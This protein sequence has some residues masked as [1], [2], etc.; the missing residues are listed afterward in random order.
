MR[1]KCYVILNC[2]LLGGCLS[3][4]KAEKIKSAAVNEFVK[5]FPC[6]ND[7]TFLAAGSDTAIVYDTVY[8]EGEIPGAFHPE[9]VDR[10]L[11]PSFCGGI[12]ESK[13]PMK[14]FTIPEQSKKSEQIKYIVK[15][16]RIKDTVKI[17]T[18]D[19]RKEK[20]ISGLLNESL[21]AG[22]TAVN[23]AYYWK[24]KARTRF[25]ILMAIAALLTGYG[26]FRLWAKIKS[27]G[28]KG[29]TI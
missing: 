27:V 23:E 14:A 2:L 5:A 7:S 18:V 12:D 26:G 19:T 15:T 8:I 6:N 29:L 17:V 22:R 4:R 25:W 21:A 24:S 1:V 3:E 20:Y 11:V 9:Y 16:V 10:G 13:Y 28:I